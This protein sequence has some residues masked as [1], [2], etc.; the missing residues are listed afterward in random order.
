[1][2]TWE[3]QN[4]DRSP[5]TNRQTSN[6]VTDLKLYSDLVVQGGPPLFVLA[7]TLETMARQVAAE[8]KWQF[9]SQPPPEEKLFLTTS[10]NTT[11]PAL[12]S[13]VVVSSFAADALK[14]FAVSLLSL[15]HLRLVSCDSCLPSLLCRASPTKRSPNKQNNSRTSQLT[16]ADN[17]TRYQ[18]AS[19]QDHHPSGVPLRFICCGRLRSAISSIRQ[20]AERVGTFSAQPC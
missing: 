14:F 13:W 16:K 15:Q 12:F 1:M 18:N 19:I 4:D 11:F 17:L 5:S 9:A 10:R 7:K 2:R 20:K 3:V 8:P 6:H